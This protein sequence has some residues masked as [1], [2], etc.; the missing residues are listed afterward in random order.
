MPRPRRH[1]DNAVRMTAFVRSDHKKQMEAGAQEMGLSLGQFLDRLWVESGESRKPRAD[2]QPRPTARPAQVAPHQP[3]DKGWGTLCS[4]CGAVKG[5]VG[6]T[7][8]CPGSR[9]KT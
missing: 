8:S 1:E 4:V 5:K 7:A 3:V 6:W 9:E 2:P